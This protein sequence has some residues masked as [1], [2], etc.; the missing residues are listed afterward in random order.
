MAPACLTINA[1]PAVKDRDAF[2]NDKETTLLKIM[3][4]EFGVSFNEFFRMTYKTVSATV[5][6][7]TYL[8]KSSFISQLYTSRIGKA[9]GNGI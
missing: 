1:N 5:L 2:L 8:K 7:Q 9:K 6:S 4:E 3:L